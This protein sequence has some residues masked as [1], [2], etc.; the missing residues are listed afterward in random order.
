MPHI[1]VAAV[2]TVASLLLGIAA[3]AQKTYTITDLGTLPGYRDSYVWEQ[4]LN[5]QGHVV[6]YANNAANPNAFVGDA[7]FFWKGPGEVELLPGFPDAF[8][9]VVYGLNDRDQAVGF[10]SLDG[11]IRQ[12]VLW[13]RGVMYE[14]EGLPDY[15]GGPE[16]QLINNQGMAVG[17]CYDPPT[18]RLMAVYWEHGTVHPLSLLDETAVWAEAF[19]INDNGKIVGFASDGLNLRAVV[20]TVHHGF[21]AA[22]A[23]DGLG[24][25]F[26]QAVAINNREQI[27]GVAQLP[28]GESHP[29]LWQDGELIDLGN[30]G[31]DPYGIAL[32]VNG[33]GQVVGFSGQ[34]LTDVATAHALLWEKGRMLEL[35]TVVPPGS[36]W[37]L[38]QASAINDK[39]QIAGIGLHNGEIRAFLLTPTGVKSGRN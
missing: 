8:D 23:L 38:L 13:D 18:G 21:S 31:T 36:G 33:P 16:A 6:A 5:N 19:G 32:A 20:W 7:A 12:A 22:T 26:S 39:G 4:T 29:I 15:S 24:G 27:V 25:S 3:N 30:F 9:T 28:S 11:L 1:A 37:V 2:A 35:Q 10:T 14:L 17:A 34:D